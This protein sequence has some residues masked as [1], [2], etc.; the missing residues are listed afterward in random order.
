[1]R[2]R[3]GWRALLYT[4]FNLLLVIGLSVG[5]ISPP[6]LP[7]PYALQW[8][9]SLFGTLHPAVGYRPT[10]IGVRQLIVSSLFT[11]LFIITW[12]VYP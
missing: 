3:M 8:A 1:M 10:A 2:I 7:L 4:S 9:E 12:R 5:R 6:L 11:L